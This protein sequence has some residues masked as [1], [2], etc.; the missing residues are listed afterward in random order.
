MEM[1]ADLGY[2]D[3]VYGLGSGIFFA[4]YMVFQVRARL[5]LCY[6]LSSGTPVCR[7]AGSC[8]MSLHC[9]LAN[10]GTRL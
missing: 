3:A 8:S 7:G 10:M 5:A 9:Y 1:N 6:W 4:G 2:S